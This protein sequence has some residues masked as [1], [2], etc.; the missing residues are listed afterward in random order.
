MVPC[1]QVW[2]ELGLLGEGAWDAEEFAQLL[3]ED[4]EADVEAE[5][6]EVEAEEVE[7]DVEAEEVEADVE[8]EEVEADVEAEEV[9]AQ[10]GGAASTSPAPV[11]GYA[12]STGCSMGRSKGRSMGWAA[13][14]SHHDRLIEARP[15]PSSHAHHML[16]IESSHAHYVLITCSARAHHVLL[17]L[18]APTNGADCRQ[19]RATLFA[20]LYSMDAVIGEGG[21]GTVYTGRRVGHETPYALKVV[22]ENPNPNPNHI[23]NPNP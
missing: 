20:S 3:A 13:F 17:M 19:A 2:A 16:T 6:V 4:V 18:P 21:F 12:A 8:A 22:S 11:L 5:E 10:L 14:L 9:E 23:P 7:A 15:R 1:C